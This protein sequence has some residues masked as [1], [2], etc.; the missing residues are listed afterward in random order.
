MPPRSEIQIKK[1]KTQTQTTINRRNIISIR[2]GEKTI[3]IQMVD[4]V[5]FVCPR[6]FTM[7][8]GHYLKCIGVRYEDDIWAHGRCESYEVDLLNF[9][10]ESVNDFILLP[11]E[12]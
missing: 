1:S 4:G 10:Q 3:F 7:P 9:I 5:N 12:I 6:Y 8:F 2:S 11:K